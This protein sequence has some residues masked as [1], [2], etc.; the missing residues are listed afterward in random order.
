MALALALAFI[1]IT[2]TGWSGVTKSEPRDCDGVISS[3]L[4]Y[5]SWVRSIHVHIHVHVLYCSGQKSIFRG[6]SNKYMVLREIRCV[7]LRP[8]YIYSS[9]W[10]TA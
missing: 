6:R 3:R 2:M 9:G 4:Y 8:Y 5:E 7:Y 1:D 10:Q